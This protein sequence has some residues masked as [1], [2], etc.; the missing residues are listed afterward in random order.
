MLWGPGSLHPGS[1]YLLRTGKDG[2]AGGPTMT[3][4]KEK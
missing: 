4:E 2:S 3:D 1:G